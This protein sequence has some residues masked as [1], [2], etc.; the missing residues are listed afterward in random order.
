MLL[1]IP[2]AVVLAYFLAWKSKNRALRVIATLV[3]AVTLGAVFFW[4]VSE[5]IY[6]DTYY[7]RFGGEPV[8]PWIVFECVAI[9]VV[10]LLAIAMIRS[11]RKLFVVERS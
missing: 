11:V 1:G 2:A 7:V 3:L 8:W 10:I 9:G 6:T 5:A 4:A